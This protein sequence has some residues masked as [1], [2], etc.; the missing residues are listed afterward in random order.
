MRR[1][2]LTFALIALLLGDGLAAGPAAEAPQD[3]GELA[4]HVEDLR[5]Q[6]VNLARDLW[7]LEQQAGDAQGRLVVFLSMDPQL[8]ERPA[9]IELKLG[10]ETIAQHEYSPGETDALAKGGAHRVYAAELDAGRYVLEAQLSFRGGA[11]GSRRAMLS[12][13]SSD[14]PKTIELRLQPTGPGLT[15]LT[16]RE[17]D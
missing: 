15:E 11:A 16:V 12:F 4:Q 2:P 1:F 17:W 10:D 14:A 3:P 5:L 9:S 7:L 6:S 13:R 8:E